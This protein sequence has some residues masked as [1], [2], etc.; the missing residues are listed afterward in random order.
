[1]TNPEKIKRILLSEIEKMNQHREDF[2]RHPGIDFTRN[3]KI[4]FDTLL[5]F[6]ISMRVAPSTMNC[7]SILTLMP[8]H[9]PFL[10]FTSSV[11][12]FLK[13]FFKSFFTASTTALNPNPC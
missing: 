6:Q 4:S 11:P 2:Y 12:N 1:M 13:M 5:H 3:R 10:R 9:R 7:S 8:P